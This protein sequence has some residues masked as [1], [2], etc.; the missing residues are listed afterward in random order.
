MGHPEVVPQFIVAG[1][2]PALQELGGAI[3]GGAAGAA[4]GGDVDAVAAEI[5]FECAP[6]LA[7]TCL[8]RIRSREVVGGVEVRTCCLAGELAVAFALSS[9]ILLPTSAFGFLGGAG[10]A[11][12]FGS[13]GG[14]SG[15]HTK[16]AGVGRGIGEGG[17]EALWSEV[18]GHKALCSESAGTNPWGCVLIES[19]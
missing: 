15:T 4:T 3:F 17:A 5:V 19:P 1:E 12:V 2:T 7:A 14:S 13:G 11:R 18:T 10:F 9:F 6:T 16:L 8:N